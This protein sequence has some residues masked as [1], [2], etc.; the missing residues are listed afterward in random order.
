MNI[1]ILPIKSRRMQRYEASTLGNESIHNF[2]KMYII[3]F[4][5]AKQIDIIF[6]SKYINIQIMNITMIL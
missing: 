2:F 3:I 6:N 4:K 5:L 1:K